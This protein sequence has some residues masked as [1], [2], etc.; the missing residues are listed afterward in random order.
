M[1]GTPLLLTDVDIRARLKAGDVVRL[2]GEAID[3]ECHGD[4][5]ALPRAY[6]EL[7]N[8]RLVFTAARLDG[9]WFNY[10]SYDTLPYDTSEPVLVVHDDRFRMVRAIAISDEF[11]PHRVGAIG[12]AAADTLASAR[13]KA[14]AV[15]GT[16][17]QAVMQ[18]WGLLAVRDLSEIRE[19]ADGGGLGVGIA[20]RGPA[21]V[22]GG[23]GDP[24]CVCS[25][26]AR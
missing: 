9:S 10:R 18:V 12:G 25:G 16:G 8:G 19:A 2:L 7:G 4:L 24:S 26:G 11:R 3:V 23:S 21:T 22:T 17:I 14:A 15:I 13:A 20:A 6:A 5:Q 1:P